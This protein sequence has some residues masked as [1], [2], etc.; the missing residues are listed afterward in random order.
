MPTKTKM[1][2]MEIPKIFE[3]DTFAEEDPMPRNTEPM[4]STTRTPQQLTEALSKPFP[5]SE[6]KER[7]GGGGKKLKYVTGASVIRRLIEATENNYS[8]KLVGEK[9]LTIGGKDAMLVIVELTIPQLGS[10]QGY[11]VQILRGGEDMYKGAFTDGLKKAATQF[12][13]GLELYFEEE[14]ADAEAAT[15]VIATLD[16]ELKELLKKSGV[17]TVG[18]LKEATRKRFG[19]DGALTPEQQTEWKEELSKLPF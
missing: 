8:T 3:T 12:G 13:V 10:R 7:E 19:T 1:P 9:Y 17:S 4:R 15:P 16:G 2:T 11:G 6:I 5:S 14:V 18:A